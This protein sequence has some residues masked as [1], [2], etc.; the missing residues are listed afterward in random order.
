[1]VNWKFHYKSI[2]SQDME[3]E[4][5]WKKNKK[6]S[7]VCH[8]LEKFSSN[9][10]SERLPQKNTDIHRYT[11]PFLINRFVHSSHSSHQYDDGQ[12]LNFQQQQQQLQMNMTDFRNLNFIEKMFVDIS[13][14]S[15][16][17]CNK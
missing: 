4:N 3:M 10:K 14:S 6:I 5:F 9:R 17:E 16:L 13:M 2:I 15:T 11:L 7:L 12:M 1:M 8:I